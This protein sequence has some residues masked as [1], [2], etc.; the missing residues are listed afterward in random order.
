MFI[1]QPQYRGDHD[2]PAVKASE[3]QAVALEVLRGLARIHA[4]L[5]R[6]LDTIVR[7]LAQPIPE[8]DRAAFSEFSE[9]FAHFL[10]THH[11]GEEEI[12]FPTLTEGAKRASI[13]EPVA[14]VAG[15]RAEHEKLVVRLGEFEAACAR[16]RSG[17][18]QEPLQRAA[19]E[20]RELLFPHLDAEE[21]T[22]DAALL[23]K[24][25]SPAQ[26]VEMA[27]AA[28]KHGQRVGGPKALMLLVHGLSNEEQLAQFSV[29]PWFVRKVLIKRIWARSFRDCLK[30]AHNGS[31][32]L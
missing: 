13:Q 16:F 28:G 8:S 5:R 11:E 21:A 29:V 26:M 24:L 17:G 32:A 15:W 2:P 20:V 31:V 14:S 9:R 12:V 4:V 22:L 1:F 25:L 10:R 30:Y 23:G 18:S 3:S 7:T 6:S 19:G 27:L